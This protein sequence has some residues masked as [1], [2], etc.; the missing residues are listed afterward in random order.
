MGRRNKKP[1]IDKKRATTYNLVF[2]SAE[3]DVDA[4]P[5]RELIAASK[6]IGVG[7][8]DPEAVAAAGRARSARY[9]V[10]HPLSFLEELESTPISEERRQELIEL[11][12]PDDGYD[13]LKHLRTLGVGRAG[14]EAQQGSGSPV[15]EGNW[16]GPSIFVPALHVEPPLEDIKYFDARHLVVHQGADDQVDAV[17]LAG[18]VTALTREVE[19]VSKH[20]HKEVEEIEEMMRQLEWVDGGDGPDGLGTLL[21][22]F[23]LTATMVSKEDCGPE[24]CGPEF[25]QVSH[26]RD[27]VGCHRAQDS[28]EGGMEDLAGPMSEQETCSSSDGG[29]DSSNSSTSEE[30]AEWPQAPS[31]SGSLGGRSSIASNYWRSERH[32]RKNGLA[33]IDEQ[34]EVVAGGYDS[35]RIGDLEDFVDEEDLRGDAKVDEFKDVFSDFLAR[36]CKDTAHEAGIQYST[37]LESQVALSRGSGPHLPNVQDAAEAVTLAFAHAHICEE[38]EEASDGWDSPV[39]ENSRAWE[40]PHEKWDCE[41]VLSKLSNLDNHPGRI[42]DPG[43]RNS[44][45]SDSIRFSRKTGLPVMNQGSKCFS[46]ATSDAASDLARLC[47][48]SSQKVGRA[49]ETAQEK[50]AR[51]GAVKEAKRLS[52]AL[53]KETK[54][55]FR[56]EAVKQQMRTT[57]QLGSVI[58]MS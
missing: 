16:A 6:N 10:G 7:R 44:T 8:P 39:E 51:K 53:K 32:D 57:K 22:D 50:K 26:P 38:E 27:F 49:S 18:G 25:N 40:Q 5:A 15:E 30:I 35:D 21:D 17:Q 12:F 14:L 56:E 19:H 23:V 54:I 11:G 46:S 1:F 13:Y 37:P 24:D 45:T 42:S 31:V 41:S 33:M 9:P 55:I 29:N 34:F 43:K 4:G 48:P 47:G 28:Y 3:D 36:H 58:Q 20:A 52:R 2:R